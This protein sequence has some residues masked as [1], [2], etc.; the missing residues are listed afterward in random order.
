MQCC[1]WRLQG[2]WYPLTGCRQQA[3]VSA[4]ASVRHAM[5]TTV[6]TSLIFELSYSAHR[7]SQAIAALLHACRTPCS[8]QVSVPMSHNC[9]DTR[10]ILGVLCQVSQRCSTLSEI[11]GRFADTAWLNSNNSCLQHCIQAA[12]CQMTSVAGQSVACRIRQHAREKQMRN[13]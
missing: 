12:S 6:Q 2:C 4:S 10:S 3:A 13:Q 8:A 11:A 7:F 1:L 9:C 5:M